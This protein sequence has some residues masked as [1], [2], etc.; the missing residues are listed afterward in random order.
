MAVLTVVLLPLILVILSGVLELGYVRLVADRA[1]IAADLAAVVAVND[2]DEAELARTGTLRP[3]PDAADV[4]RVH[5]AAGLAPIAGSLAESPEAV[6]AKA[7]IV[8]I[9]RAG[10]VDP[11]TGRSYRA[12]TVRI[13]ADL[14]ID[15]PAFAAL[16]GRP[17]TVIHLWSASSAR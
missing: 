2:Q 10:G 16:L 14:P 12:P 4:A 13:A 6:A 3:A 5:L 17:I 11:R 9:E 8:V 1:R 7:D 15:T